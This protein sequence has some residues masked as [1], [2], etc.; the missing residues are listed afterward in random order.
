M[1]KS[2]G[3]TRAK[4]VY[5]GKS[6]SSLAPKNAQSNSR[7]LELQKRFNAMKTMAAPHGQKSPATS[8][9]P[10]LVKQG[11]GSKKISTPSANRG[12]KSQ[13]RFGSR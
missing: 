1:A 13:V 9:T 7:V 10:L 8:P 2:K 5:N 11:G 3:A 12:E 6:I 4:P